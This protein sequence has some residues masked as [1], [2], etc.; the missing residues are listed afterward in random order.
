HKSGTLFTQHADLILRSW[1]P[2]GKQLP[3]PMASADLAHAVLS[4]DAQWLFTSDRNNLGQVW[5]AA[6]GKAIGKPVALGQ[7]IS[8]GAISRDG[9]LI[10]VIGSDGVVRVWNAKEEGWG[11]KPIQ[12]ELPVNK[13]VVGVA[14]G[15][16]ILATQG[17]NQARVW[18]VATGKVLTPPLRN[19]GSS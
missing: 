3:R 4:D 13:M 17:E 9:R 11:G 18:D 7:A 19:G 1:D 12:P 10:A 8:V 16:I 14:G 6:S 15:R 5:E 2:N